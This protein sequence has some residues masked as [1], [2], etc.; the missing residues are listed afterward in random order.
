MDNLLITITGISHYLGTKPFK[1]KRIVLL[2]KDTENEYDSEAIAVQ[3]P[4]IDTIG[5]VA[6]SVGT[7]F[8]GTISAGRLYDRFEER[9]YAEVLVVM[10]NSVIA[11]FVSEAEYQSIAAA[12]TADGV[13]SGTEKLN[14]IGF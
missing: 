4:Y 14:R 9:A 1:P 5:Y 6:N 7:V 11:R 10:P 2:V 8:D 12:E 3:L 13:L